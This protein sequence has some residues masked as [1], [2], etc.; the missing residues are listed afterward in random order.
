MN[1]SLLFYWLFMCCFSFGIS[2]FLI[3][4]IYSEKI[5]KPII[6]KIVGF[7]KCNCIKEIC[8]KAMV[9]YG[10]LGFWGGIIFSSIFEIANLPISRFK[11][12]ILC[13]LMASGF[14]LFCSYV[15]DYLLL[16]FQNRKEPNEK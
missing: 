15:A 10:C 16:Q 4:S 8:D 6:N 1:L 9:C 2:F 14:S 12:I 3:D 5:I 11:F 13:G 7:L